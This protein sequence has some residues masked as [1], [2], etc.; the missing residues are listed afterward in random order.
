MSVP[1]TVCRLSRTLI[2]GL[3]GI[4]FFS[5]GREAL[6]DRYRVK[7]GNLGPCYVDDSQSYSLNLRLDTGFG[8]PA[9]DLGLAP[10]ASGTNAGAGTVTVPLFDPSGSRIDAA[11]IPDPIRPQTNLDG[12]LDPNTPPPSQAFIN[13]MRGHYLTTDPVIIA[14]A[15]KCYLADNPALGFEEKTANAVLVYSFAT[16]QALANGSFSQ[17]D[18]NAT[19]GVVLAS[20]GQQLRSY[21]WGP[22]IGHMPYGAT[23]NLIPPLEEGWYHVVSPSGWI[24]GIWFL[25]Q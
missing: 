17:M 18:P 5:Y 6:A 2:L 19:R 8:A 3:A 20:S 10:P 4:C 21:P 24:M 25:P 12:I 7:I 16:G 23:V 14:G 9:S 15:W 1:W 11:G 13:R 22:R